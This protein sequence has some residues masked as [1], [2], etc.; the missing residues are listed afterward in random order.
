MTRYLSL[1]KRHETCETDR[2]GRNQ[3][4]AS[5]CSLET[6]INSAAMTTEISA[7]RWTGTPG[8]RWPGVEPVPVARAP[9][10]AVWEP[11]LAPGL[12]E[13]RRAPRT[14]RTAARE[15]RRTIRSDCKREESHP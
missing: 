10:P 11:R 1:P 4:G 12:E 9:A 3:G 6:G 2:G 7:W 8:P 15:S 14:A 5:I 13:P